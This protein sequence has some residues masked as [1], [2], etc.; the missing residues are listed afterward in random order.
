MAISGH[1]FFP[2][3]S[4]SNTLRQLETS[5]TRATN[6]GGPRGHSAATKPSGTSRTSGGAVAVIFA[7]GLW[8]VGRKHKRKHLRAKVKMHAYYEVTPREG[9][10]FGASVRGFSVKEALDSPEAMEQIRSDMYKHRLLIFHGQTDLMPEDHIKLSEKLGSLD[11]ILHRPHP[12]SPDPRLLRVANDDREGFMSV[13]T[14]G[15]HVDGVMLQA[16]FAAQTMHH[17]HAIPGGDTRFLGMKELYNSMD[18]D[19]RALCDRLW[20]VSGVGEDLQQGEGQ[21]SLL[22]LVYDHPLSDDKTMCFHL[23]QTYCLG[24]IEEVPLNAFMEAFANVMTRGDGLLKG[25][26]AQLQKLL[27]DPSGNAP[28]QF[29]FLPALPVQESIEKAI[30]SMDPETRSQAITTVEW[31]RGDLALIDNMAL[32]HVPAPGTQTLPL[33]SG[34]RVFHRTTMT[35]PKAVPRN[36][37]GAAAVLLAGPRRDGPTSKEATQDPA[38][39]RDILRAVMAATPINVDELGGDQ[40]GG[41][42]QLPKNIS[43]REEALRTLEEAQQPLDLL[44]VVDAELEAADSADS[45]DVFS[46]TLKRLMREYHPD[47]NQTR[48]KEIV[49]IF[50]YLWRLHKEQGRAASAMSATKDRV[51]DR[52][53]KKASKI[54]VGVGGGVA[55]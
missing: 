21:M 8:Q 45:K 50:R 37:R 51:V 9:C 27:V 47:R 43:A 15:W 32:A 1:G 2:A 29:R 38:A 44:K 6:V 24:F 26:R 25:A 41:D 13:G 49:P 4:A 55:G 54:S 53:R 42:L 23:G 5:Q 10:A 46:K 12:K 7:A 19:F 39:M 35:N 16:P 3:V 11:H 31:Q 17:L 33:V 48:E 14:S 18:E 36:L 28:S 34:L 52:L 40:R 30:D 20:F 22:P